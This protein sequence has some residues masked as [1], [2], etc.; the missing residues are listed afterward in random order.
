MKNNYFKQSSKIPKSIKFF[1]LILHVIFGQDFG[2]G[3]LIGNKKIAQFFKYYS[4]VIALSMFVCLLCLFKVVGQEVWYWCILLECVVNLC[5]LNTTK[6]TVYNLLSEIH[7]AEKIDVL[8]KEIFGVIISLYALGMFLAKGF[9]YIMPL[10]KYI[11]YHNIFYIYY[12]LYST[13]YMILDLMPEAQIFVR[14]Y[15]YASVKNMAHCLEQDQD[16]NKFVKRYDKIADCQ[17]KIRRLCDYIVSINY[18]LGTL[19]P[20]VR[21]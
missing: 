19:S 21:N 2:F 12:A 11:L 15:I 14:F 3:D 6:Y 17:D 18:Y 5:I 8:E 1:F 4:V 10:C 20:R 13:C 16:L 9:I 7:A